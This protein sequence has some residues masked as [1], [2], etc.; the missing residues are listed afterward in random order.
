[1]CCCLTIALEM[2]CLPSGVYS[3]RH[4]LVHTFHTLTE[5]SWEADTSVQLSRE[6]HRLLTA[7]VWP[8]KILVFLGSPSPLPVEMRDSRLLEW[9]DTCACA[10]VTATAVEV[11]STRYTAPL[12]LP[13]Q[14]KSCVELHVSDSNACG[15]EMRRHTCAC[16]TS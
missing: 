12:E 9:C 3:L 13:A 14:T 10:A 15:R 8:S 16:R 6:K 5:P 1:M 7:L 2:P 11:R 4:C